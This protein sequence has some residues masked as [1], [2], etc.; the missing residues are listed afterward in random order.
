M[1]DIVMPVEEGR[2]IP[3]EV[4]DGILRQGVPFRLWVSTRYGD[5]QV[6]DARDQVKR[7]GQSPHVLMLDNDIVLPP[8]GLKR[9]SDFLDAQPG[10]GAIALCKHPSLPFA[11]DD[12]YL[13][14]FHVDMSCVLF[15]KDVLDRLTF[16]DARNANRAGREQLAGLCECANA[17][18]DIRA[19]SL[20]IGFLPRLYAEHLH[21]TRFA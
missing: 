12:A 8:D 13:N 18:A 9:M 1:L 15:R 7:Y 3:P 10:F 17:C 2:F 16:V 5:R 14:A 6:A 19:T 11:D 4:L 21:P 20:R